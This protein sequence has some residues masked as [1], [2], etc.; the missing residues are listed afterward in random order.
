MIRKALADALERIEH[1]D[2]DLS[3]FR[4]ENSCNRLR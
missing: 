1:L 3:A 4:L 2:A